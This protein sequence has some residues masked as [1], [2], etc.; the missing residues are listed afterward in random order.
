MVDVTGEQ[1]TSHFKLH[2]I[3][4]KLFAFQ[5]EPVGN[6]RWH[7]GGNSVQQESLAPLNLFAQA[8]GTHARQVLDQTRTGLLRATGNAHEPLPYA[9]RGLGRV[10]GG[11]VGG[12]LGPAQGRHQVVIR[13]PG[14]DRRLV[15]TG[16]N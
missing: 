9:R 2:L 5:I 10:R 3:H 11:S 7:V 15:S 14:T 16:S 12:R 4:L 6:Q 13:R 1:S 8:R